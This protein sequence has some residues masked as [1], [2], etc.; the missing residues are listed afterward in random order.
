MR[1]E[2]TVHT[3][4]YAPLEDG[5]EVRERVGED[6]TEMTF[7]NAR[8]CADWLEQHGIQSPSDYPGPY[9]SHTWLSDLDPYEHPHTGVLFEQSAHAETTVPARLWAAIVHS[10]SRKWTRYDGPY[11]VERVNDF[12][13]QV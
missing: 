11:F 6:S 5:A 12:G 9:W 13:V 8:E 7:D 2:I 4:Q 3:A 10:V 1:I